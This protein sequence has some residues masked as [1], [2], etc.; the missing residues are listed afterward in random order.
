MK[1]IF[2]TKELEIKNSKLIDVLQEL[3]IISAPD[4]VYG[5]AVSVNEN[6]IAKSDYPVF[7]LKEND[8]LDVFY[9]M[10][11]GM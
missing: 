2:N 6:I 11:G 7:E 4:D 8:Q 10:A 1:I 3:D 5:I 9:M